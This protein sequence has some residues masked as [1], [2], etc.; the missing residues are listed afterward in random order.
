M[1]GRTMVVDQQTTLAAT[2]GDRYLADYRAL[3]ASASQNGAAW[4]APLRER[5]WAQ[6]ARMGFPVAR[7][8]NEEWKYTS[9][10]PVDR[11]PFQFG[12]VSASSAVTAGE[13]RAAAPWDDSWHTLLF[14]DGRYV[15]SLSSAPVDGLDVA[16]FSDVVGANRGLLES[17]FGQLAVVEDDAFTALNTAFVDHGAFV[18]VPEGTELDVPVHIAHVN[19][20]VEADRAAYPRALVVV[21]RGSRLTLIETYSSL[22]E[23]RQF[24]DSVVEM[25]LEDGAQVDHYRI[26]TENESTFH[27]GVTRVH[28]SSDSNLRSISFATGPA[29]GRNDLH[30]LLDG[31]GSECTLHGLYMTTNR[32]HLDNHISTTHAKPNGTSHQFYKGILAGRSR[33]VFSGKVLVERDAQK[34]YAD[35]KDLNLLLSKGAEIDTMPS[36]EIYADDVQCFH[37][38]TAGHVDENAL[39]YMESRGVDRD[40]AAAMLIRGFASEIVEEFRP[41]ALREY[42]ERATD[43]LLPGFS[44]G[45]R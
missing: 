25:V 32:Q 33:A 19:T 22:G 18:H 14:V 44:A 21:G 39:F 12:A 4:L 31:P 34:S 38:A 37:G 27:I 36:L 28:Q 9:V 23:K 6:F 43:R 7:R 10:R 16:N 5:A 45:L 30:V 13:I 1:Q 40:T 29:I 8:G 24:T 26:L 3:A 17:Q 35:Q 15:E 2:H 41:Q 20:N 42:V 11:V